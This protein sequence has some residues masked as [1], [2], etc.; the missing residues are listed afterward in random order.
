VSD[1]KEFELLT[2]ARSVRA[3]QIA[4]HERSIERLRVCTCGYPIIQFHNGHGHADVCPAAA[5]IGTPLRRT[6]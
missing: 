3:E 1:V 5:M 2:Q 4:K 6:Q